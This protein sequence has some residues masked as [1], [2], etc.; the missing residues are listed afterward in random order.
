MIRYSM[1]AGIPWCQF[2]QKI[3]DK[4]NLKPGTFSCPNCMRHLQVVTVYYPY[5]TILVVGERTV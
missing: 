2:C 4:D 3:I 5:G 1:T